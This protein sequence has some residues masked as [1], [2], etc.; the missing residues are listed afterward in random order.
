METLRVSAVLDKP[1]VNPIYRSEI[2]IY[3]TALMDGTCNM[4]GTL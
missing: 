3:F 1:F 2:P 4:S